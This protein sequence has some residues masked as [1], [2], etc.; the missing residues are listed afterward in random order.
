[1]TAFFWQYTYLDNER[2]LVG[3]RFGSIVGLRIVGDLECRS[4]QLQ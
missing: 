2:I 1:M 4:S 3:L